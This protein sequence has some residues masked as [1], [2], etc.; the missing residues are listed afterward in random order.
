MKFIEYMLYVKYYIEQFANIV[1]YITIISLFLNIFFLSD[2]LL[3]LIK[4]TS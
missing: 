4:S 3:L 1:W 2:D